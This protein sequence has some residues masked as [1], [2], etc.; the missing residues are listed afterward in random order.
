MSTPYPSAPPPP[1]SG[2]PDKPFF[3]SLF[4]LDFKSFIALRLIKVIYIIML[5]VIAL[6]AVVWLIT[7]LVSG[8]PGLIIGALI[9]VPIVAFLYVLLT[10]IYLEIVAVLFR[11]GQNTST[12]VSLMGGGAQPGP[13][14]GGVPPAAPSS[15][16]PY[17]A[18]PQSPPPPPPAPNGQ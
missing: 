1:Q 17:G 7:G 9:G 8:E 3:Q 4:D 14:A 12:L 5:V 18:P 2:Q 6:L 16:S 15:P 11:I 10:R 13:G